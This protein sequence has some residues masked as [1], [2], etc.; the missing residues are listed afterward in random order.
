MP[1]GHLKPSSLIHA[2][3]VCGAVLYGSGAAAAELAQQSSQAGGLTVSV[4]PT[5][6]SAK[7]ATWR[8]QVGMNTHSVELSDD[9]AR[10]SSLVDAGGKEQ[11]AVGW[12]GDP[13]GGHHRNG[14]LRFKA[15]SPR[16]D[17]LELRIA[18]PGEKAPRV[19]RWKLN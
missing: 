12:K 14:E 3:L 10:T 11:P 16:P 19:F 17:A 9:L 7:A 2:L 8:F 1:G 5:D 13:P 4:K 18:R 6:V 15:L